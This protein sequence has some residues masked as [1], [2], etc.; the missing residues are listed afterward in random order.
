MRAA[1][2]RCNKDEPAG[3]ATVGF[4]GKLV[5]TPDDVHVPLAPETAIEPFTVMDVSVKERAL[6]LRIRRITSLLPPGKSALLGASP[7]AS[8][9]TLGVAMVPEAADAD[10]LPDSVQ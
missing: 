7:P 10:P 1:P 8:A 2:G 3:T 4:E 5:L 9:T 6:G